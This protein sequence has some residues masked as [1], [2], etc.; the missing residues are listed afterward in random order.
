MAVSASRGPY[1][2]TAE[3]RRR[4]VE[5]CIEAFGETG[6]YGAT[7]KDVA[8]RAGMSYTGLLHH[9]A[10]KEDL[11]A[12][13]LEVRAE[14]NAEYLRGARA[15]DPTARPVEALRGM[16]DIVVANELE[17]GMVELSCVLSGEATAPQ[18]PAHEYFAARYRG[19]RAFYR[20]AFTSLAE[21]GELR[22][23]IDPATLATMTVALV[24]GLQAQWL[25][26]RDSVAM[27]SAIHDYLAAVVPS[28]DA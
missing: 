14:R 5:A 23:T 17:P 6:F 15:L 27:Q 22:S 20:E 4:I 1:A 11:L 18:H 28:L 3:V 21:R 8:K 7:M 13:V 24:N 25:F 10:T 12:A 2:K 9:F 26:D 19:L 16:L